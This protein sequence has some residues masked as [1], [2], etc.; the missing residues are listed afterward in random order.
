MI[1]GWALPMV[2]SAGQ[3]K[4]DEDSNDTGKD[5]LIGQALVAAAK[6]LKAAFSGDT[7]AISKILKK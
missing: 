2:E 6:L 4:I 3:A 5:D 7:A 1:L